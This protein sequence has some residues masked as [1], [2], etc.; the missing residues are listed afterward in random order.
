MDARIFD[1]EY[2]GTDKVQCSYAIDTVVLPCPSCQPYDEEDYEPQYQCM[3][4]SKT[5][6]K[7]G[8][9]LDEWGDPKALRCGACI[10]EE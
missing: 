4:Y 9:R 7:E 10:A 8:A 2:C 6:L 1:G 5:A 3:A